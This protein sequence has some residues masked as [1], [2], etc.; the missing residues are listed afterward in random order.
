MKRYGDVKTSL[1]LSDK[2]QR[3]Y[4]ISDPLDIYEHDDGT[5]SMRGCGCD[6]SGY[7]AEDVIR[8]LEELA[9]EVGID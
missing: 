5:Y 7:A 3:I 8:I 9:D 1:T 6:G 4:S 2:A